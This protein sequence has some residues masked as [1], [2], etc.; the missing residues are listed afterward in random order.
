MPFEENSN[1]YAG[2]CKKCGKSVKG[3]Y[4]FCF[5]CNKERNQSSGQSG[6]EVMSSKPITLE[7]NLVPL[8]SEAQVAKDSVQ[9]N[10]QNIFQ[11]LVTKYL[12]R[13]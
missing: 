5:H 6:N 4:Q 3:S 2:H 12:R 10:L 1:R 7:V 9:R 13:R 11:V 8:I